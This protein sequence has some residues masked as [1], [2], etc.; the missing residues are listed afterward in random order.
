MQAVAL[1]SISNAT[2]PPTLQAQRAALIQG[3]SSP[4]PAP[5]AAAPALARH[6]AARQHSSNHYTGPRPPGMRWL[7]C[8]KDRECATE[9]KARTLAGEDAAPS[10]VQL[11]V[12]FVFIARKRSCAQ[13]NRDATS[14]RQG[15]SQHVIGGVD[16]YRLREKADCFVELAGGEGVVALLLEFFS[17]LNVFFF[18]SSCQQAALQNPHSI[19]DKGARAAAPSSSPPVSQVQATP[20]MHEYRHLNESL[21]RCKRRRGRRV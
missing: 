18:W 15:D 4:P 17:H 9:S 1:K 5:A 11:S 16:R 7:K 2:C 10:E 20:H 14:A 6:S 19:I 8:S 21:P 12:R 13:G 3:C